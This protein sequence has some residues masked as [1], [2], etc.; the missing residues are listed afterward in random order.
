[1]DACAFEVRYGDDQAWAV[2]VQEFV[3]LKGMRRIC[4]D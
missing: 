3:C 1:M 4:P 2:F